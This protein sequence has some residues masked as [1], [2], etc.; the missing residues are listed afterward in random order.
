MYDAWRDVSVRAITPDG[1]Y[2]A[3]EINPQDGDGRVEFTNLKTFTVD[4]VKR[5]DNLILTYDSR[6]AVMKIKPQQKL[7]KE[8]RRQKKERKLPKDSW[9]YSP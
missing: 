7:V 8:L 1:S 5:A 2:A 4:S 6:Y 9:G 3:P